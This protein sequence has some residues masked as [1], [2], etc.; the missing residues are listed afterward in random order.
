MKLKII[1]LAAL[2][3]LVASCS[4]S[5]QSKEI[6]ISDAAETTAYVEYLF[7]KNGPDM[8]Q[9]SFATMISEWNT[10]QDG[11]ENP[12][13]MSVGLVPR[14][15]TDLYDGMWV[16]VWQS[17]EQSEKG[18]EEWLAGPAEAWIEKTSSILSCVDSNGDAIN[19]SFNVSNFRPAQAQDAEPGGVVGFNFCSYNDS[20]GPGELIAANGIYNQWLD[21]AVEAA[22]T[23]TPYFYTIH[24]P[25]FETPIPGSSA[26]SYDYAFHHFW[27][28]EES[29]VQGLAM[30]EQTAP[31]PQGPQPDCIQEP[32]LFDSYPFRS[33]QM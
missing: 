32:F 2:I 24:E 4:G 17:K 29:R 15:E 30:F 12:V 23:S 5:D 16:L 1:T 14:T 11:M 9:E 25:N 13:P 7:C 6:K 18:W 19:Y 22:G 20:F 3:S 33:P 8:S 28:S 31:A 21:A 27:D 26:G 10:I